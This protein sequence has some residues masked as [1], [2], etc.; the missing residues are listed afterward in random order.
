MTLAYPEGSKSS[1]PSNEWSIQMCCLVKGLEI[2]LTS[3]KQSLI[4]W[5]TLMVDGDGNLP[6]LLFL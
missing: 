6:T 5:P 1:L 3:L 2:I 4:N